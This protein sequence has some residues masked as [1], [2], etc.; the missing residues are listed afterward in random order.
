MTSF[1]ELNTIELNK[2]F[3]FY[4]YY[5]VHNITQHMNIFSKKLNLLQFQSLSQWISDSLH[6]RHKP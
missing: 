6:H 2:Q 3:I 4:Y 1:I 5:T